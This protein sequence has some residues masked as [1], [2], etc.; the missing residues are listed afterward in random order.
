MSYRTGY[1]ATSQAGHIGR[2]VRPQMA[3]EE[4]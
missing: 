4:K 3:G 1:A 2:I